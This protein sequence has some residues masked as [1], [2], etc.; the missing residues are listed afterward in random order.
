MA[1]VVAAGRAI[2]A[3]GEVVRRRRRVCVGGRAIVCDASI[4]SNI[5]EIVI[6]DL[7]C[8]NITQMAC[9]ITRGCSNVM[10]TQG[11]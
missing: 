8:Y 1:G 6:V 7:R 5:C 9:A 2:A 4:Y 3:T 10:D 11:R